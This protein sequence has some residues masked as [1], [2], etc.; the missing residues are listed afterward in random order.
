MGRLLIRRPGLL[1]TVQDLGR[2]GLGRWGVSPSGAMDPLALRIANRLVGN[3]ESAPALEITAVGPE[4]L[5]EDSISFAL[6]G[7]HLTPT[8]DGKH[9]EPW[10]SYLAEAGEVL[11]FGARPILP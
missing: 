7:S 1:T 5:F 4:I 11:A 9:I 8:L 2:P 10:R 6:A 3:A